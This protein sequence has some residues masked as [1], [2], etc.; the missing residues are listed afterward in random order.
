M[1]I[2]CKTEVYS[3]VKSELLIIVKWMFI[4]QVNNI[5]ERGLVVGHSKLTTLGKSSMGKF[6]F[7]YSTVYIRVFSCETGLWNCPKTL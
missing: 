5:C 7:Y 6:L 3:T 4:L 1:N 2:F